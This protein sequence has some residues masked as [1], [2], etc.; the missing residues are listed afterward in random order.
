MQPNGL[1]GPPFNGVK[2]ALVISPATESASP[3]GFSPLPE[4]AR[5]NSGTLFSSWLIS[6]AR[7]S[8]G[9]VALPCR[10]KYLGE[11]LPVKKVREDLRGWKLGRALFVADSGV[12][13]STNRD[14]LARGLRKIPSGHPHGQ[15]LRDQRRST[16]QTRPIQNDCRKP[17]SQRSDC[18]RR[19]VSAPLYS[20]L[21]PARGRKGAKASGGS[22]QKA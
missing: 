13:S 12:N 20:L 7:S 3:R 19:R 2:S 11:R 9:T 21:Q 6:C 14:E 16:H 1:S 15:R 5:C 17:P 8:G 4:L 18:R 22:C 10:M